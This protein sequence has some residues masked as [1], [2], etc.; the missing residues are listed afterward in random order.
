MRAATHSIE[1]NPVPASLSRTWL[2]P[3][4]FTSSSGFIVTGSRGDRTG[5]ATRRWTGRDSESQT[6]YEFRKSLRDLNVLPLTSS[7]SPRYMSRALAA[8]RAAVASEVD[9]CRRV[10]IDDVPPRTADLVPPPWMHAHDVR[11]RHD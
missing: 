7:R 5:S 10:L 2:L 8:T 3:S 9:P 4:Q 6:K 11:V 1:A